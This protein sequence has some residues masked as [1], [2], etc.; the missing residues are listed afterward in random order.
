MSTERTEEQ[1][2]SCTVEGRV[3]WVKFNRP[4]KRNA[5]SPQLNRQMMRVLDDLEFR[6]DVGVL[7][8]AGEGTAWTAGMDL[9]EYFRETEATGLAG[10]RKAQRES[11]GWWRR[12][13]WFQKPTIAMVNGWCFGG[14]YGPL[15]ACDLAFA[16]DDAKFGL[17]E[18]NWGILP[19]G[20]A[21][22]VAVE[23]LSFRRA[24]YHA[25]LGENID[26]RTAAEWGLVNESL[27]AD[28]LQARVTEV[29][30]ALLQKNPSAL[31]ATKDAIRRVRD[32]SY[33]NAEDY[34]VRAQ[35][36]ANSF[37]NE[38]RKEGMRQFLD[39]KTYKPGLGTYDLSKQ[40]TR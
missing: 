6:D 4:E 21:S 5:M 14:G 26:G 35:E 19:G 13:R 1:T 2:V 34:L 24:M 40:V 17:S 10:T 37:D 30:E 33:D 3:A 7:V 12:L 15:F 16:S 31:K 8:L 32:M 27:P 23:L 29:A 20:G 9:K 18:I 36:A 22:K 11:Y 39:D 28:R 25:M 38:G